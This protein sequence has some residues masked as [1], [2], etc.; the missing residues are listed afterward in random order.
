VTNSEDSLGGVGKN[1]VAWADV[2]HVL[3]RLMENALAALF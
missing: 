3:V 1:Q 2:A